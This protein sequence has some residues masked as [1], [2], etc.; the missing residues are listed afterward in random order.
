VNRPEA[1][2]KEATSKDNDQQE[3]SNER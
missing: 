2:N 3:A 1:I